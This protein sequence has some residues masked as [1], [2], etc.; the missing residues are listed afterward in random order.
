MLNEFLFRY[1]KLLD[2]IDQGG[3]GEWGGSGL[4]GA[5][6]TAQW[7][8][9]AAAEVLNSLGGPIP[10]YDPEAAQQD[11]APCKDLLRRSANGTTTSQ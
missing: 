6:A 3:R 10:Y 9:Y 8:C 7:L 4:E 5:L 2:E 11:W 1:R